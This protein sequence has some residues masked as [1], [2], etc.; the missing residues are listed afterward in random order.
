MRIITR[1]DFDGVVCAVLLKEA[2][3][4]QIPVLWVQPG[5]MQAGKVPVGTRD[6]VANLP[7]HGE[8]GL[9][10]DHHV[11]NAVEVPFKG[12]YRVAPSAAG[13]VQDYFEAQLGRRFCELVRQTDR[14]DAAELTLDEILHPE[15]YP[16]VLLSMT[17]FIHDPADGAYCDR[18]V[19]L[20]RTLPMERVMAD[21]FVSRR[22]EAVVATNKLYEACLKD[23]TSMHG[24]ISVTDLR[25]LQSVPDGN[26]FLVYSL[27]PDAV[28]NVKI[29]NEGPSTLVKLGHSILNRGCRVNVGHLLS[30]Y[31]GGG[32]VGAGACR[33]ELQ[34]A[35]KGIDEILTVLERNEP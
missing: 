32:H 24:H 31:G 9:W 34:D 35:Q 11:S 23:H 8:A 7:L 27:F 21:S 5:D 2:L 20:L 19:E 17:I 4:A 14:I 13:L 25:G 6:V 15:R 26:R 29:S 18:A 3:G 33:F 30:Q 1:P 28:V 10:F 16:F 22:C 12:V